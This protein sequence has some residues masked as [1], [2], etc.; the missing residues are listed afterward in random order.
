MPSIPWNQSLSK[1]RQ[2][3]IYAIYVLL[4]NAGLPISNK[5]A[6]FE[7]AADGEHSWSITK[8]T[9]D[10]LK[11]IA[12]N[13]KADLLRRAH[14]TKRADRARHIFVERPLMGQ[15]ELFDY[16]FGLD[17]VTLA[18]ATSEAG[19]HGHDHFSDQ[20]EVPEG[21][22]TRSGKGTPIY[23]QEFE[24]AVKTLQERSVS[25]TTFGGRVRKQRSARTI[26]AAPFDHLA[27]DTNLSPE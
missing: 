11:Y 21:L 10:A 18:H 13:G 22:F 16:F 4:C 25:F 5:Q 24:W 7:S 3:E 12:E 8:I 9:I 27:E 2:A 23:T 1:S 20:V 14:E 26:P 6:A 17:W 19:R 15:T